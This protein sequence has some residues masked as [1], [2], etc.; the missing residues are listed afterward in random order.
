MSARDID[1]VVP[2]TE[3]AEKNA[4]WMDAG[5]QSSLPGLMTAGRA[6]QSVPDL[7]DAP[8]SSWYEI[9]SCNTVAIQ[10]LY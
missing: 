3:S 4:V 7:S 2:V 9:C 5:L 1:P 8:I 10:K 6:D